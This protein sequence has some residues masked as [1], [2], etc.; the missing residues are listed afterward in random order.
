MSLESGARLGPYE[1]KGEAGAGGMG[2]VYRATDTRLERDVAIKV[3]PAHLSENEDLKKR[4]DRE[5]KTISSL[6]HP[7]ICALYDVGHEDGIDFL[8]ME[9][10]E[11]DTLAEKLASGPMPIE[12]VMKLG[13]QITQALDAAHKS[14]VIHRDLKPGNIMVTRSGAKLLDFGLAKTATGGVT[15]DSSGFTQMATAAHEGAGE[16]L[17]EAGTIL[18]TF[19]YMSPEQLEGQDADARSDIFAL[20]AVLYEMAAGK[21]AFDGKGRASLIA[22]IMSSH[23]APISSIQP[24]TP[25]A[26]DRVIRT[27]LEKDPEARWQTAHD[28][29]L[30]LQWIDEGGSAAGIP[31]PVASRRR[32]RE[33]IAW[34]VAAVVGIAAVG[35]LA[36]RLLEPAPEAPHAMRVNISAPDAVT[37]FGSP[38]ISPDGRY[39]AFDGTDTTG[40]VQMWL[41]PMNTLEA[42]PLPGTE[43]CRR[44]LWSPDSRY[45]AFFN[46]SENKLMRVPVAGGPPM[47]V[48]EFP[49]GSD[50][51]WGSQGTII[52]DATFT[53]SLH[54]V[55]AGG[56]TPV[57][58][59]SFNRERGDTGHGWPHFLP[60]GKHFVFLAVRPG[61]TNEIRLGELGT[62][63]T[64]TLTEADSRMEYL[65]PGFLVYEKEGTLLAHPID[66]ETGR[67]IGDPFPLA[68]G[69]GSAGSLAHFSGSNNGTLIY[70][71]EDERDLRVVWVTR[72]GHEAGAVTPSGDQGN[73]VLSP[74]Q[75]RIALD[76]ATEGNTDIWVVDLERNVRSRFTFDTALDVAPVWSPDGS[77]IMWGSSRGGDFDVYVKNTSGTGEPTL[78]VASPDQQFPTDWHGNTVLI[79]TFRGNLDIGAFTIGDTAI[80]PL[81]N[82]DFDEGMA[83]FSPDGRYIAYISEE[84]GRNEIFISTFP[85]GG[86]KW[87]V[88]Q[89]GG[90]EPRWN[91]NGKELFFLG[92]DRR[93]M[94]VAITLGPPLQIGQPRRLFVAS[95]PAS[96]ND[97][98]RFDPSA[99]GS[100]FLVNSIG[101]GRRVTPATLIL[102]WTAELADR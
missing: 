56:G 23:P 54:V 97:R 10:L 65:A 44:P 16:S 49:S 15:S 64:V 9:Y 55:P 39:I 102:N 12:E 50:G 89:A 17:T 79:T 7:N 26:L 61:Q 28:V 33:R 34:I 62:F 60:D 19:Q 35:Q 84:T 24:M 3:L 70:T 80:A 8:V 11:G 72:Q 96:S 101:E 81:F 73:M 20:G 29:A 41:R 36:M 45:V 57:A 47:T 77:Q 63:E 76:V 5:A 71:G 48:C 4:F 43:N 78:V 90:E 6:Q 1:I 67:L 25:P 52:F 2:E 22:S 91:A 87:L 92:L 46:V 74:D 38:R 51:A 59:T 14:G 13:V 30:Q 69:I 94:T 75:R 40:T 53:D 83:T 86:G 42:F 82:T 66:P 93:I 37:S 21:K 95:V 18:G 32:S 58:A 68:D 100:R 98:N 99:D 27:C 88:S 31:K 85:P